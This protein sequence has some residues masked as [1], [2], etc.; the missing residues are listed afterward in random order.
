MTD[1]K[2]TPFTDA[3]KA[4]LL[5]H[6]GIPADSFDPERMAEARA[7]IA[8]SVERAKYVLPIRGPWGL[9][10]VIEAL[11]AMAHSE[12]V[13]LLNAPLEE[14]NDVSPIEWL[15]GDGSACLVMEALLGVPLDQVVARAVQI[16]PLVRVPD[17]LVRPNE[18]LNGARPIDVVRLRGPAEVLAAVDAE[19]EGSLG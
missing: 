1:D 11:P 5:E 8:A 16:L 17:W 4:F 9:R 2:D 15:R 6:A 12:L 18:H 13:A 19:E 14:L 10:E 7:H 3:E